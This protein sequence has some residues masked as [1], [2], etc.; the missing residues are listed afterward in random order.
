MPGSLAHC[1]D[2]KTTLDSG[3]CGKRLRG[4]D[5]DPLREQVWDVEIKQIVTECFCGGLT[6][7]LK[8]W[9]R[10]DCISGGSAFMEL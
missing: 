9:Q 2:P 6:R 1:F 7:R 3:G 10:A 4:F 5:G 8:T